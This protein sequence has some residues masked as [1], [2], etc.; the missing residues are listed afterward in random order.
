M[1]FDWKSGK[2]LGKG[3]FGVV[4]KCFS[5]KERKYFAVKWIE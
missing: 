3:T 2:H 4:K 5:K 1:E